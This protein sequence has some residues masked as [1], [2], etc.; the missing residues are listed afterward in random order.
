MTDI[1]RNCNKFIALLELQVEI[2]ENVGAECGTICLW[3]NVTILNMNS[4]YSRNVI[5]DG[6][7]SYLFDAA[8]IYGQKLCTITN[9]D[10]IFKDNTA[11]YSI[12]YM[13][14]HGSLLNQRST[15][16]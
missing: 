1:G 12:I 2:L 15:F 4:V 10:T 8:G 14:E 9:I 6:E 3:D 7:D 16:R 13:T 11:F 5:T